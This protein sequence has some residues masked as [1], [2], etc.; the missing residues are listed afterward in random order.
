M[1]FPKPL[2]T[3]TELSEKIIKNGNNRVIIFSVLMTCLKIGTTERYN[4]LDYI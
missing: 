1:P 3:K 2:H 4:T